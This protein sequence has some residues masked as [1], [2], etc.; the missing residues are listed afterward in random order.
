MGASD[1]FQIPLINPFGAIWQGTKIIQAATA[2]VEALGYGSRGGWARRLSLSTQPSPELLEPSLAKAI[3]FGYQPNG[4]S[5]KAD[6]Q[7]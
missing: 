6:D 1:F 2:D 4:Q 7:D 3:K 5:N